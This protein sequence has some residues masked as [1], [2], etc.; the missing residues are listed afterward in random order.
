MAG[1]AVVIIKDREWLVSLATALWEL[2]QGLG[3]LPELPPGTG[4][5]FDLG[6]EQTIHVTTVPMLFPL[7]MAFLSEELTVIEVYHDIEPGYLVTST[8]PARYFIEVN[9]GE[10]EGIAPADAVSVDLLP[11]EEMPVELDWVSMMFGLAGFLILGTLTLSITSD[12]TRKAFDTRE[13]KPAFLPQVSPGSTAA[14]Y[15]IEMDRMGN[16]IITRSDDPG[17]DVFLQFESDKTLV[18]ELLKKD[19][20]KDLDAGWKIRLKRSE[21]RASILDELWGSSAQPQ[22]LPSTAK[23]PARHDVKVETWQERDRLGIWITDNRTGKTIAEWWDEDAREMFEQG[24]FKSGRIRQQTITGHDF[25]E[26]VLAYAGSVGILTATMA[27][28]VQPRPIGDT[29]VAGLVEKWSK[30]KRNSTLALWDIEAISQR[31]D[32]TDCKEALFEYRDIDR[33]DYSDPE[34][35]QEARDEAWEAFIE[36]LESLSEEEEPETEEEEKRFGGERETPGKARAVSPD[37]SHRPRLKDELEFLPD[38]P[39]FLAYTIEDIGYR[40]RIDSAFLGAI[41]RARGKR[42]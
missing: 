7:D 9:A 11:F 42:L 35:Y 16:I 26:S 30:A 29:P 36:C 40:D 34:E 41:A 3:G 27:P 24:F 38:S 10:L 14:K 39:E 4:M 17:K 15:E 13:E 8:Q 25:E 1:Q 5:L 23:K 20:K 37:H 33:S 19:E 21:P 32:I 22:K 6:F 2:E 28:A 31:Y 12:L 18:Y